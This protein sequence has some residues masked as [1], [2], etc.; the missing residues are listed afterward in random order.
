[1]FLLKRS[2]S[3]LK[4]TEDTA[5]EKQVPCDAKKVDVS[6]WKLKAR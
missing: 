3:P 1:M 5:D 6:P 4:E 2:E